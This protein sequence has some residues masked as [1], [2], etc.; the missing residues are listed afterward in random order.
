MKNY[1]KVLTYM[2]GSH[3]HYKGTDVVIINLIKKEVAH[4]SSRM[5]EARECIYVQ[6]R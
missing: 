3:K 6:V 1:F 5:N 2:I 4:H